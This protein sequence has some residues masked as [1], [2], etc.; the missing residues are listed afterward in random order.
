MLHVFGTLLPGGA[1]R[2]ALVIVRHSDRR[3]F[4]Y[5]AVNCCAAENLLAPEFAAAGCEMHLLDKFSMAYPAFLWRLRGLI[6]R[7]SPDVVHTWLYAPAF[8]G[9][10]AAWLAGHRA[11]VASTRTSKPY[12]R[13]HER[14]LDRWLSRRTTVRIVNSR[15][16]RDM[17]VEQVGIDPARITVIP[18]GVEAGRFEGAL[19][20]AEA[21]AVLGWPVDAPIVLAVGRLVEAKNYELLL[22]AM[23][24]V[25][26]MVPDAR[27]YIAGW[28]P[29]GERLEALRARLGLDGAVELLGRREDVPTLVSAADVYV[30][31]SAWEGFPNALLE[32]MWSG[33]AVVSTR[34]SGAEELV[35]DGRNGFLVDV[36]DEGN[37]A[38]RIIQLLLD[39]SFRKRVGQAALESVRARYSM[40]AMVLAHEAVYERAAGRMA[41][42]ALEV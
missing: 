37:L 29:L 36:N 1:E 31:S 9:R 21:R 15:W 20:R 38:W 23:A 3:R 40:T 30:L 2:Q 18:N 11:I 14:V 8:W 24:H 34:V 12:R 42:A 28:G 16:I 25:R 39:A 26:I 27:A 32:A 4:R 13:A 17:L 35:L 41:S 33:A 22:R 6:R 19:P 10:A 5:S 7:L